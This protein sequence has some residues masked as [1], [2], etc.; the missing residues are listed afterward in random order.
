MVNLDRWRIA[1]PSVLGSY[2]P[3]K[4]AADT[5]EK[6]LKQKIAKTEKQNVGLCVD[7]GIADYECG[8][9]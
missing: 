1:L 6:L 7:F 9:I 2:L 8:N 4:M 3:S 5:T